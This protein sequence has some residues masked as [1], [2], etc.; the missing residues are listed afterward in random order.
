MNQYHL[1]VLVNNHPGLLSKVSGLFSRRNFNIESLAVGVAEMPGCSRMT[2]VV[3]GDE[4]VVDQVCKQLDKLIDVIEIEVL[5]ESASV[6]RELLLVKMEATP[7]CRAEILQIAEIFRAHIVDVS[8]ESL[9]LEITGQADKIKAFLDMLEPFGIS[10]I[11]RTG[12]I[13]MRRGK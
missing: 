9:T 3:S 4:S 11:I 6:Q 12:Q 5:P 2:I 7:E 1:S 13:A 10:Q 8:Q